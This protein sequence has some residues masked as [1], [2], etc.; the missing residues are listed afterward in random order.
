MIGHRPRWRG[1]LR[2]RV[3]LT[4]GYAALFVVSAAAVLALVN[5]L[6]HT[7]DT[8]PVE[9]QGTASGSLEAARLR[10]S[11]LT[12]RLAQLHE[13]QSGQLLGASVLALAVASVAA[14]VVGNAMAGRV[15]GPLRHITATTRRITAAELHERLAFDG[16]QD[17]VRELA[18]TIDGLLARLETAFVAQRSFVANASHELRTPLTTMRAALDVA[19][20]KGQPTLVTTMT[21]TARIRTEL[22]RAD[23]LL[24]GLLQL[25][26]ALRGVT[27]DRPTHEV[28]SLGSVADTA[29][30]GH[31]SAIAA[32]RLD[33]RT[34]PV[35]GTAQV[36]GST[37]LLARMVA[38]LVD[39]A[40]LHGDEG[41]W[42][43]VATFDD[44]DHVRLVVENSGPL[45]DAETVGDL[46]QPFRR[47]G[48]ERL[49]AP[50][51]G[52]GLSIVNAVV[53]AHGGTTRLTARGEGGLLVDVTLPV[54]PKGTIP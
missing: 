37:V 3:R 16:P 24:D 43:D 40:V 28:V 44:V 47:A 2:L 18:D 19:E 29:L 23:Q 7:S 52:L 26:R 9:P 12:I 15:I 48:G 5:G 21:L 1:R 32:R 41:G 10:I 46:V 11:E 50:G 51:S 30:A 34:V 25:A 4:I 45:L 42:L 33:V 35:A 49:P 31:A 38:N 54:T 8:I 39:N 27:D 6:A 53:E 14:V 22:D 36:A 17:E 13:Q 20:A